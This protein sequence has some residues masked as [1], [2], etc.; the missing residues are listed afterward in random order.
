MY[1]LIT[2]S[3]ITFGQCGPA[4]LVSP[5][6]IVPTQKL[7]ASTPDARL[8]YFRGNSNSLYAFS[9][10]FAQIGKAAL[11]PCPYQLVNLILWSSKPTQ[12]PPTSCG[13]KPTNQA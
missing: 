10:N 3:V 13:V 8:K 7:M 6:S 2:R 4:I 11:A 1:L 5:S 12:T 9:I